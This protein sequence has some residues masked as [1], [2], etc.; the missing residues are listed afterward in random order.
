MPCQI[1]R[2]SILRI[3]ACLAVTYM[4]SSARAGEP[5]DIEYHEDVIYGAGDGE[6]LRL[7]WAR[8]K[9]FDKPLT[10]IVYIH[11][12]GW[13]LGDK[14]GH[15]DEIKKAAR[16]GFFSATVGYRLAP[17]HRF[18]AQVE[19]CKCA[20]RYLRANADELGLDRE[21]IGAIGFSAGAHLV[22]MLATMDAEDGL[23]GKGGWPDWSSKIQAG[24]S[25]FGP[26]NLQSEFPERSQPLVNQFLD[27]TVES[28]PDAF[29][30]AS[31]ITYVNA[32]DA[33]LLMYQGT[34]DIL[35]P[36]DQAFQMI[37]ALT[38]AGVPGRVEFLLGQGH[39]WRDPEAARTFAGAIDFIVEQT[40]KSQQSA[41]K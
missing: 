23:E 12:G 9:K 6:P 4:A 29:R 36:H 37:E 2:R 1:S 15:R 10:A 22:M 26:T 41:E 32:G 40:S 20:I 13:A 19:D 33:P 21:K 27:G 8:P 24:V 31:P 16:E 3:V 5:V 39:G 38:A 11:G 28:K 25:F 7:D 35:V 14:K 18:P 30:L 34:K 17:A